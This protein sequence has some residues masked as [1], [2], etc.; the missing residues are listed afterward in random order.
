MFSLV[1]ASCAH[2]LRTREKPPDSQ[3]SQAGRT[4]L[5]TVCEL[6]KSCGVSRD[7]RPIDLP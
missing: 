3:A 4:T 7:N 5:V 1:S 6:R 2:L